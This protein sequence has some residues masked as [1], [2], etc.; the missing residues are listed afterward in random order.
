M[1]F[2][3]KS[4]TLD[5]SIIMGVTDNLRSEYWF[6]V[7]DQ[8]EIPI[9]GQVERNIDIDL[10][11]EIVDGYP[12][13][14]LKRDYIR[15]VLVNN[16]DS[17]DLLRAF[18]GV[19]DK[20]MYLELSYKFGKQ[21]PTPESSTNILGY[22]LYDLQKHQI[23]FFKRLLTRD[24]QQGKVAADIIA[25]YLISKG[26]FSILN[27]LKSLE[28]EQLPAFVDSLIAPKEVQQAETK[29]RGH[30]AE[31]R[32]AI[33]LAELGVSFLPE[34][35][36]INPMSADD[37]NVKKDTFDLS[38]RDER[39]TWS[40]DVIIKDLQGQLKIF[41]QGLIHTSD[42]GQY[43]VN[44]SGETILVKLG[45]MSFNQRTHRGLELWG[46]VDGVGFIENPDNTVFKMLPAFDTFVQLKSLYKAA[47][48]LHKLGIVKVKAIRFDMDF[49][50]HKEADD[51]FEK[52]GSQDIVKLTDKT[53][54]DGKEI[55]AGKAWIYI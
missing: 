2:Y 6:H 20:R 41:T 7:S 39:T 47:L 21:K 24:D 35:K 44:K 13:D 43:G 53:P 14:D 28:F 17:V 27:A 40:F 46:L 8:Q 48:R 52:Y 18:V 25:D 34:N 29:R 30:G 1:I 26:L 4:S 45:M 32:F 9:F 50:T 54:F 3:N 11:R 42:P 51:M 5:Y 38:H 12:D 15:Q 49:Y 22:T 37:P 16:P 23:P 36:H 33:L 55:H 31:Q 19:S 10:L